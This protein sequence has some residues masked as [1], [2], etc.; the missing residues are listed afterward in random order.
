[1]NDLATDRDPSFVVL[2]PRKST[3]SLTRHRAAETKPIIGFATASGEICDERLGAVRIP[4]AGLD[5]RRAPN[6]QTRLK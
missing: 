5:P 2:T 3:T 6:V 1:M 4:P